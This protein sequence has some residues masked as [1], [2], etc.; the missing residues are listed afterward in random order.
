MNESKYPYLR[1]LVKKIPPI[2]IKTLGGCE[3]RGLL[4]PLELV[5]SYLRPVWAPEWAYQREAPYQREARR[6]LV[7]PIYH[8]EA[9]AQ[10]EA[11]ATATT[12]SQARKSQQGK[13]SC[14]GLGDDKSAYLGSTES[15]IPQRNIANLCFGEPAVIVAKKST[16][17]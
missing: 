1:A 5:V 10:A 3:M 7:T 17:L 4:T 8:A 16:K 11:L 6:R 13:R 2:G 14:G 9:S 12:G 15:F